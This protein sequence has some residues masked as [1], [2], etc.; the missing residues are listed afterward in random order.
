MT[1][2]IRRYW[3]GWC[4]GHSQPGL[5]VI[6]TASPASRLMLSM[7]PRSSVVFQSGL[8]SSR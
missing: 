3:P 7:R 5:I 1:M 4:P 6:V 8:I 2:P